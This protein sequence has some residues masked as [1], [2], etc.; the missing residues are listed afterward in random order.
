MAL[1]TIIGGPIFSGKG[2]MIDV[3]VVPVGNVT[4]AFESNFEDAGINQTRHEI[5]MTLSASMSFVAPFSGTSMEV[6]N[7]VLVAENV[8]VGKVPQSYVNVQDDDQMLNL[9]PN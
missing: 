6:T 5:M 3:M 8:I 4:T 9:I 1:G 7:Q 2:P